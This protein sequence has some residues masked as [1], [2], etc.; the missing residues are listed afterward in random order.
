MSIK[1]KLKV[2]SLKKYYILVNLV[3]FYDPTIFSYLLGSRFA[4]READPAPA[5]LYGS[6]RIL[7]LSTAF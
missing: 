2:I 7:I 4:L 5:K 3:D 6:D 1:K